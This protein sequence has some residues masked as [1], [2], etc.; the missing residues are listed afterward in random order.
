[1][2]LV[3]FF[4]LRVANA[5]CMMGLVRGKEEL[6]KEPEKKEKCLGENRMRMSGEGKKDVRSKRKKKPYL[7]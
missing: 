4:L 5:P 6:K 2:Q 3:Q 1:M 7:F